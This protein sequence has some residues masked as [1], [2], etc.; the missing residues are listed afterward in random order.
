MAHGEQG[1][2]EAPRGQGAP[3]MYTHGPLGS[4]GNSS[5]TGTMQ[6]RAFASRH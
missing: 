2:E 1:A 3:R 5:C 4:M 6:G